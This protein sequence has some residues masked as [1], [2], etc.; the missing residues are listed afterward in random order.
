MHPSGS[1]HQPNQQANPKPVAENGNHSDAFS[2]LPE[3]AWLKPVKMAVVIMSVLIVVGIGLLFYGLAVNIGNLPSASDQTAVIHYPKGQS[4]LG[5]SMA[6]DGA[7]ILSFD[8]GNG[9]ISLI[10][11][12]S[13]RQDMNVIL[14][15]TPTHQ[16]QFRLE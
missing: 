2:P 11:V 1:N 3:P 12:S 5:S 8:D 15:L 4:L 10:R 16:P 13:D 7:L 6:E 9:G 14:R